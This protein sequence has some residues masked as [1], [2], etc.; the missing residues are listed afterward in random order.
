MT[1]TKT[2]QIKATLHVLG[3]NYE[4]KGKTVEEVL[5]KLKPP[6][7]KSKG[8]LTLEKG[9]LKKERIL[10]FFI[11]NSTFGVVSPT[12]KAFAIKNLT[13]LFNDFND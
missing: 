10:N 7:V 6:I 11:V 8:I 13:I 2:K 9:D 1:K 4:A 12:T 3:R 5:L